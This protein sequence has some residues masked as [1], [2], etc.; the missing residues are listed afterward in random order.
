MHRVSL[1]S[2]DLRVPRVTAVNPAQL[3]LLVP[4]EP[5]DQSV[6]QVSKVPLDPWDS[7][8]TVDN[9][10]LTECREGLVLLGHPERPVRLVCLGRQDQLDHLDQ[11]D[12]R[13]D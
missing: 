6:K 10:G 3:E 12:L 13:E 2:P 1:V 11:Q 4:A 9:L 7:P 8:E 5:R